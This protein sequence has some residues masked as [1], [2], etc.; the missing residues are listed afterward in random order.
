MLGFIKLNEK[1]SDAAHV[2]WFEGI[3]PNDTPRNMRFSINFFTSIGLGGLTDAMRE[4]LKKMQQEAALKRL[5]KE[6]EAEGS[7]SSDGSESSSG[8]SLDS[9]D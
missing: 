8:D 7:D 1:L 2:E 9:S 4:A 3:F 6:N 5:Q